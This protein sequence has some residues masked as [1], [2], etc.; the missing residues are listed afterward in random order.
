M[1]VWTQ[2]CSTV[3]WK[4]TLDFRVRAGNNMHANQLA[5]PPGCSSAGIGRSFHRSDISAYKDSYV[6]RS[7]IL[8]AK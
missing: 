2:T 3:D 4:N 5:H 8:F 7:Y 6:A 1:L